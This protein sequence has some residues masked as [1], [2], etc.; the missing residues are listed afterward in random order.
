MKNLPSNLRLSV[1][2]FVLEGGIRCLNK[3]LLLVRQA[4]L[5]EACQFL[6]AF[7]VGFMNQ[8]LTPSMWVMITLGLVSIP[9]EI[10]ISPHSFSTA[11]RHRIFVVW[12][13]LGGS[14]PRSG[15]EYIYNS[16]ILHPLIGIAK[17]FGNAF[18]W[19]MWIYVLAPWTMD[20][21]LVM[22]FQFLDIRKRLSLTPNHCRILYSCL[23][24]Y[25]RAAFR[26]LWVKVFAR[27]KSGNG[28]W[29]LGT[30]ISCWSLLL[31]RRS[32]YPAWDNLAANTARLPTMVSWPP[33]G[34]HE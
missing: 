7:G 20:P 14:M 12:G 29:L 15:G 13:I 30:L 16:R 32:L 34:S 6:D 9:G 8:G 17:S 26:C 25:H 10:L 21:G 18:V 4:A 1:Y 33:A 24:N 19:I 22:M 28:A 3:W 5:L 2:F 23:L 27:S 11:L 31:P